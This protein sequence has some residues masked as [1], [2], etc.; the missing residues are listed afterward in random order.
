MVRHGGM[1]RLSLLALSSPISACVVKLYS[2]ENSVAE[3]LPGACLRGEG[4]SLVSTKIDDWEWCDVAC[5]TDDMSRGSCS[6]DP[7]WL[8]FLG[9]R[10]VQANPALTPDIAGFRQVGG[11]NVACRWTPETANYEDHYYTLTHTETPAERAACEQRCR[12]ADSC[13]AYEW[14]NLSSSNCESWTVGP[15]FASLDS[16]AAEFA[17]YTCYTKESYGAVAAAQVRRSAATRAPG[18]GHAR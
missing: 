3:T 9:E 16:M 2:G 10:I 8:T 13:F 12:Y 15:V 1:V 14:N 11:E 5:G 17:G 4:Q 18:L 7:A 6:R